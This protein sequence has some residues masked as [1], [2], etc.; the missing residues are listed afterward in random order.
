MK[1]D[2]SYELNGVPDVLRSVSMRTVTP[3]RLTPGVKPDPH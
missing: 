1:R 2:L 3:R